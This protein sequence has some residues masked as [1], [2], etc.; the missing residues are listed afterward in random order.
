MT[1]VKSILTQIP[2]LDRDINTILR[3]IEDQYSDYNLLD[4]KIE[5][6]SSIGIL[7]VVIY[8]IQERSSKHKPLHHIYMNKTRTPF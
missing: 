3:N 1:I 7:V 5:N 2:H 6:I 4:I 8:D